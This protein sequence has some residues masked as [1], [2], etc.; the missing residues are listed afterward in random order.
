MGVTSG[1]LALVSSGARNPLQRKGSCDPFAII[2][3]HRAFNPRS[4]GSLPYPPIEGPQVASRV[5]PERRGRPI[6]TARSAGAP[7]A[8]RSCS[9]GAMRGLVTTQSGQPCPGE[10][11][12]NRGSCPCDGETPTAGP[13]PCAPGRRTPRRLVKTL[14]S[15]EGAYR[16][17]VLFCPGKV[18]PRMGAPT[19]LW[20]RLSFGKG[21]DTP[22]TA[23]GCPPT[24]LPT[25]YRWRFSV[26]WPPR[27]RRPGGACA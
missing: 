2:A 13:R 26:A 11:E 27:C 17:A 18:M 12:V 9:A 24:G 6:D 22:A 20:V 3:L 23:S 19:H 14:R 1:P 16:E 5:R 25:M 10:A 4:R 21:G 8:K 7:A 15:A